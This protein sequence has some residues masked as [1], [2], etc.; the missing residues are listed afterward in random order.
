MNEN[1][2][3][4]S[5][6]YKVSH[7]KQ[8]PPNTTNVYSYFESRGSD[9]FT[10]TTFFGLQY[11][12]KEYLSGRR[13]SRQSIR[14]AKELYE[15]HFGTDKLFNEAGWQHIMDKH[16]GRLPVRIKAVPE[17][18]KVPVGNVM[19]TI[20]NTDPECFWLTNFLE[21]ILSQVWYPSTVATVSASARKV[22]LDSLKRTGDPSLIDFKLHDF[23][24]RGVS[25]VESAGIGGAAHL[26][27]FMGTD[28][29]AALTFL[30]DYYDAEMP[31]FSVPASEHS[32]M[33]SWG[34]DNETDA[35][36]NMIE[37][38]GDCG[39][40]SVVSDSYDLFKAVKDIWGGTLRDAVLEAPGTLV[41]RPDSGFPPH[42]VNYTLEMLGKQFGYTV[43]DKGYKVLNPKVRV[44]QG[45]G[46]N[47][48]MIENILKTIEHEKWSADNVTFGMGGGLL[49]QVNR[50]TMRFAF[51]CSSAVVDG[52][53]RNVW[54]QP[55]TDTGKDSKKGRLSL[56]D[57]FGLLVTVGE[58]TK[59][60][61]LET[62]FENG[63]IT[64]E[65]NL[66]DIRKRAQA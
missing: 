37:Q 9:D 36:R 13:V 57:N 58:V 14:E 53:Q 27:N 32:T 5:D 26:L 47:L 20:E 17:G 18:T 28:T 46:L 21:T 48:K 24:F 41:V 25:S 16:D 45:D 12:I 35:Y 59:G 33:T 52:E 64:K 29:V 51:K 10:E 39:I 50:D 43:N 15:A 54:K 19:M 65:Q 34:R 1:I 11:I 63:W 66:D 40:Y 55:A 38:Y 56:I 31:G 61:L 49:Q 6:S 8:Y 4:L 62:V 3:L 2:I 44:I 23:G 30:Q 7:W 22:I 60:D 42:I